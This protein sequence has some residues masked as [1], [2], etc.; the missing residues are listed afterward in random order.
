[1]PRSD[2]S[3]AVAS[4]GGDRAVQGTGAHFC[5]LG[6]PIDTATSQ[7]TFSLQVMGAVAELERALIHEQT[8]AERRPAHAPGRV[9]GNPGL[10]AGDRE[11]LRKLVAARD[12]S[13]FRKLEAT[14]DQWL[15]LVR[16]PRAAMV[17]EDLGRLLG[18][19][20]SQTWAVERLKR[21][22][23][24]DVRD[25]LLPKTVL[26]RA[27]RPTPDD[28]L[29]VIVAGMR[30]GDP[31]LPLVGIATRL[32]ASR[33]RTPAATASGIPRPSGCCWS[34]R[35]RWGWPGRVVLMAASVR[36]PCPSPFSR[37]GPEA[38]RP[39][40]SAG[41]GPPSRSLGADGSPAGRLMRC[42]SRCPGDPGS[43]RWSWRSPR[44]FPLLRKAA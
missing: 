37:S 23:R 28:R 2:G 5:S 15:P 22:A 4:A 21:A 14:G 8:K 24:R 42:I 10:R 26:D 43:G 31:E 12:D 39:R 38:R 35:K 41:D 18:A 36:F 29:L 6:D 11:A 7:G 3:L 20:T 40:L 1:M 16:R 17:R 30:Q 27:P 44:A 32:E 33:E 9:R 13:C 25:G 19:R 34:A